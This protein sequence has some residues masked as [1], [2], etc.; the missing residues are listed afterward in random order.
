MFD[1]NSPADMN[2]SQADISQRERIV[3]V[4]G[5][6]SNWLV[7]YPLCARLQAA[8]YRVDN[9][10]Y[11]SWQ[12]NVEFHAQKLRE[13]LRTECAADC[14]VHLLAHSMGSILVRA[15]LAM[16]PLPN[17]GRVVLLAPPNHG[18]PLAT[19]AGKW[20]G[21]VFPCVPQLSDRP[22]SFVNQ[23]PACLPVE[24]GVIAA[25]YD[26]L[27]P[28]AS[29]HLAGERAHQVLFATH[30]SLVLSRRVVKMIDSFLQT[31]EF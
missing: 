4:H 26:F 8:G 15:A 30:S 1:P 22:E 17:L 2:A 11:P 24:L 6:G 5:L 9:W 18:T 7:M 10:T 20:F 27:V 12:A 21:G 28:I 13:F 16:G 23:L 31:G 3:V 29:T 14:R 19:L 25:R